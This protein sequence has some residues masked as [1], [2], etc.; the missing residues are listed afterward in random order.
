MFP[1]EGDSCEPTAL[2][3]AKQSQ[4]SCAGI[5]QRNK[6]IPQQVANFAGHWDLSSADFSCSSYLCSYA[7]LSLCQVCIERPGCLQSWNCLGWPATTIL[8]VHFGDRYPGSQYKKQ[9]RDQAQQASIKSIFLSCNASLSVAEIM[10]KPISLGPI[11]NDLGQRRGRTEPN[12]QW[13]I[14]P[15]S[16]KGWKWQSGEFAADLV[17]LLSHQIILM[18]EII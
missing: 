1:V 5:G 18:Q 8:V 13:H 7:V 17:L 9:R 11:S 12:L 16:G 2:I 3:G 15:S 14:S 4:I 10:E 6:A